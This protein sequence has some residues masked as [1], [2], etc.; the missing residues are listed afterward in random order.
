MKAVD[1]VSSANPFWACSSD[2]T[3]ATIFLFKQPMDFNVSLAYQFTS[4]TDYFD[5]KD[6]VAESDS[7]AY[8]L[9]IINSRVF[10]V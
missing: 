6:I 7:K 10:S 2:G 8:A 4:S 1:R 9:I 5:C 3:I